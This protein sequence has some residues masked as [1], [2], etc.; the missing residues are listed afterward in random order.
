M[1]SFH[2][3]S[4]AGFAITTGLWMLSTVGVASSGCSEQEPFN[5]QSSTTSSGSGGAGGVDNSTLAEEMFRDLEADFVA[6]CASCHK[7]GG[8]ADTPFL[9]DPDS[10][11]PD[12]YEAVT[13]WPGAI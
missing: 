7:V 3:L 5:P 12:P 8:S 6:E 10:G 1:K 13:S 2:R 9:G 11:T 4:F